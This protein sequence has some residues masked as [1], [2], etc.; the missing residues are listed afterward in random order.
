MEIEIITRSEYRR[1][2]IEKSAKFYAKQ[3]NISKSNYK[4]VIFTDPSLIKE[5]GANGMAWSA[6]PGVGTIALY[7]R[8]SIGQ[9]LATIAHEMVHIKQ[10]IRG[11]FRTEKSRNGKD[12]KFWLGKQVVAKY[13]K[14]PWEVEAYRKQNILLDQ[15]ID[16]VL[17]SESK[18]KKKK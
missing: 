17:S 11:H 2:L 8:L 10:Y 4:V 7:N 15:L 3:L 1:E 12:K 5:H 9:L 18:K 6:A 16:T 13:E 14:Q